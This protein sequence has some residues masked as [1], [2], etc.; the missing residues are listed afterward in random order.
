MVEKQKTYIGTYWL[1]E[2]AAW[3]YDLYSIYIHGIK[4]KTNFDYTGK[5]VYR[6]LD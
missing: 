2:D 5:E 4:A 6:I 3:V 1:D